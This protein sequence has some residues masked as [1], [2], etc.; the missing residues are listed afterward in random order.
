MRKHRTSVVIGLGSS[1]SGL[2]HPSNG[3]CRRLGIAATYPDVFPFILTCVIVV[4]GSEFGLFCV[5]LIDLGSLFRKLSS[6]RDLHFNLC[7]FSVE[8]PFHSIQHPRC[9][10]TPTYLGPI[11]PNKSIADRS[12]HFSV[13]SCSKS[14]CWHLVSRNQPH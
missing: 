11:G 4:I 6:F 12:S 9:A 13:S 14:A 2:L 8:A 1:A 3:D 5:S 7:V 10:V